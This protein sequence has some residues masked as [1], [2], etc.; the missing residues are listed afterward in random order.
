[1]IEGS[2]GLDAQEALRKN[3]AVDLVFSDMLMPEWIA[4]PF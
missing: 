1:V 2:N 3:G 4:H